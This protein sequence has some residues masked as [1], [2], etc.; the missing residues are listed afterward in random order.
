MPRKLR[1]DQRTVTITVKSATSSALVAKARFINQLRNQIMARK[2][3]FFLAWVGSRRGKVTRRG[4]IL[5]KKKLH[6]GHG[7]ICHKSRR[8]FALDFLPHMIKQRRNG[9]RLGG[10]L[11]HECGEREKILALEK[12]EEDVLNPK[13]KAQRG[14]GKSV[15]LATQMKCYQKTKG[16]LSRLSHPKRSP[17]CLHR[18]RYQRKGGWC[19]NFLNVQRKQRCNPFVNFSILKGVF[20]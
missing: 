6:P 20:T 15:K 18:R 19:V 3:S 7:R 10:R 17:W 8:S 14:K 12:G 9:E 4:I 2:Q 11:V 5:E 16:K 13:Q 1:F